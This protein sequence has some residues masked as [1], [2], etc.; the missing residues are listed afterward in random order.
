[1]KRRALFLDRDGVINV[2]HGYV[3]RSEDFEFIDGIFDLCRY[4]H[5]QGWLL[6]VVTN[7]AGV[8][9]GLYSE[10]DFHELTRWMLARFAAEGAPITAVYFCPTHPTAGEGAYRRESFRRKPNPGMLLEAAQEHSIDLQASALVGDKG[11]DILAGRAAGVGTCILFAAESAGASEVGAADARVG[12]L[13][14][15]LSIL[16]GRQADEKFRAE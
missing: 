1:M 16:Q 3:H 4:A 15:V 5:A 2:D 11:S 7:Q 14:A 13:T 6:V 8:A 12:T 10:E 9:R